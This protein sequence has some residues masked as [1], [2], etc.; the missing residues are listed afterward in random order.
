MGQP[1]FSACLRGISLPQTHR[2]ACQGAFATRA[3]RRCSAAVQ[4]TTSQHMMCV[5]KLG[6]G[7][8]SSFQ[9]CIDLSGTQG[10]KAEGPYYRQ[11]VGFERITK[12]WRACGIHPSDHYAS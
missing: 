12:G 5:T 6:H 1:G 8:Y 7:S 11:S 4:A 2:D 3:A 9:D 10:G